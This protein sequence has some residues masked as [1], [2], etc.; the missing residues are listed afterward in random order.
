MDNLDVIF[1]GLFPDGVLPNL[2]DDIPFNLDSITEIDNLDDLLPFPPFNE[3]ENTDT[4]LN[5]GITTTELTQILTERAETGFENILNEQS[6]QDQAVNQDSTVINTPVVLQAYGSENGIMYQTLPA[7][8]DFIFGDMSV[9]QQPKANTRSRYSCD[10]RRF[11]PDSRYHPM[12]VQLPDLRSI[13]LGQN[14]TLGIVMTIVTGTNNPINK[15][16]VHV[17]DISCKEKGVEKIGY[18]CI[19]VPLS[20][21]EVDA[22]EKKFPRAS[23]LYKKYEEYTFNLTTFDTNTMFESIGTYAVPNQSNM[24]NVPKGKR[25]KTEYNLSTYKFVFHLG[26]KQDNIIYISSITC[27][28][29]LIDETIIPTKSK[30]RSASVS[31]EILS[32]DETSSDTQVSNST[33][34]FKS[35]PSPII[36]LPV[37]RISSD[38]TQFNLDD[39]HAPC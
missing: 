1:N 22:S 30:K 27:E 12:T 31:T 36:G 26:M 34:R 4:E 19:F 18:G 20:H 11:L 39:H 25:F 37:T 32:D 14:Q 8:L 2:F 29:N 16:I 7:L 3:A 35:S 33:K 28:T 6:E 9:T 15:T 17:N 10:G 38:H 24:D 13:I 23:I 21:S 5:F